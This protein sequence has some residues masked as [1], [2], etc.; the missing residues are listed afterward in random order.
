[1]TFSM[2]V[3]AGTLAA[4][5]LLPLISNHIIAGWLL[6]YLVSNTLTTILVLHD[7][8]KTLAMIPRRPQPPTMTTLP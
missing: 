7:E 2:A 8:Q 6:G 4:F 5:D 1:M 3:N